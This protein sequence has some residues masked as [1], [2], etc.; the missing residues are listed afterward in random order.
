MNVLHLWYVVFTGL[1]IWIIYYLMGKSSRLNELEPFK[2]YFSDSLKDIEGEYPSRPL[3]E[4]V[5][6]LKAHPGYTDES[7]DSIW[8]DY[9]I[10]SAT[11]IETTNYR[12]WD[13]P[14]NG[15]CA[16]PDL[17]GGLYE[18][19]PPQTTPPAPLV[20]PSLLAPGRRINF[21]DYNPSTAPTF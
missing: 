16:P 6:P 7:Y 21:Y 10:L 4:G 15:T 9:P 17:C 2:P 1:I 11:S 12:Y 14:D 13:S 3:L 8:K 5:Y 20:A 18:K 19:L